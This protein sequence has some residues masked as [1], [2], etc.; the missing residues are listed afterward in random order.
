VWLYIAT[1][2]VLI[3]AEFNAHLFP[4]PPLPL[5]QPAPAEEEKMATAGKGDP[6]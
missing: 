6:R 5:S 4:K 1:L 3:G 2:S